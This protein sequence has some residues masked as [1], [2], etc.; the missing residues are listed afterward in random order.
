MFVFNLPVYFIDLNNIMTVS[1]KMLENKYVEVIEKYV[2]S[3]QKKK[4]YFEVL[5]KIKKI[6]SKKRKSKTPHTKFKVSYV[7]F[8]M[9]FE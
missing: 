2:P 6:K 5:K 1:F 4:E 9:I 8:K 3:K 7:P